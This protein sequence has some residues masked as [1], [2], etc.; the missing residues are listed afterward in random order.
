MKETPAILPPYERCTDTELPAGIFDPPQ[1]FI[2][3]QHEFRLIPLLR[4]AAQ[5]RN[6]YQ[7][8]AR[9]AAVFFRAQHP[10]AGSSPQEDIELGNALADLAVTGRR[11]YSLLRTPPLNALDD[12]AL[13][14][15]ASHLDL[16]HPPLT[17]AELLDTVGVLLAPLVTATPAESAS[18]IAPALDRAFRV[19]WALRGPVAQRTAT[20]A[21]LGWIAVSG[22][23]DMPHRPTNVPPPGFEQYEIPVTVPGRGAFASLTLQTRFFIASPPGVVLPSSS[24]TLRELPPEPQPQVPDGNHVILFLHGHSSGAEEALTIIPHIHMAGLKQGKKFSIISFDL[25]NNGYSESFNH[26]KVATSSAT[27]WPAGLADSGPVLVPVL[28]FIEDFIVAFVDALDL[29]T[30][31]KNR[32]SG[33]IGGSLGGNM[34]LRLG[35]RSPLPAWLDAGIV[36]W[37]AASVWEPMI[38]DLIKSQ[39][40]K[41]CKDKWE[42]FENPGSRVD[43]FH[44]AYER[45]VLPWWTVLLFIVPHTQPEL[46]YRDGWQPC[47]RLHIKGSRIARREIYS[48]NFRQWHWRVAGEQLIYSHVDRADHTVAGS[49]W[50]YELNTVSQLLIGSENDNFTGSNIFD[51]TR[52]LA[53]HMVATPGRSLFL[54]DTGHSV[55]FERPAF[56]AKQITG[57]LPSNLV[58]S[59]MP[60][61]ALS[62]EITCIYREAIL[63]VGKKKRTG[64]PKLG[65]ILMASGINHTQ[66][67]PF[68][69]TVAECVLYIDYGC[70]F[71]VRR[72]DGGK[73]IVHVV[74]KGHDRPFIATDHDK[75][76]ANNLLSLPKC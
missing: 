36:S 14:S 76:D 27:R 56:L 73:T 39:A 52:T 25:P 68:S 13:A 67:V 64:P 3:P 48:A 2:D 69:L 46:W 57:F 63:S 22:E 19:A 6:P 61:M 51:A 8:L 55:H 38:H 49:P 60:T 40:P 32:F 74:R 59:P 16:H 30:P 50:R 44:E 29:I 21:S 18:A 1:R 43:Y 37:N 34:G 41:Q 45:A 17:E 31:I 5:T 54:R 72:A 15:D 4:E 75:S 42:A 7:I 53:N 66:K 28:D 9:S 65:R 12:L 71:F 33:V 10:M 23:D 47:K 58:A 24:H 35:R 11:A 62:M 26:E 20:R 70:E